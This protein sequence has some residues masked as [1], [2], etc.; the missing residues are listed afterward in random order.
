MRT[1][2]YRQNVSEPS[3]IA[4]YRVE[5]DPAIE[6]H[7]LVGARPHSAQGPENVA[8]GRLHSFES[9]APQ[10]S[11]QGNVRKRLGSLLYCTLARFHREALPDEFDSPA[12]DIVVVGAFEWNQVWVQELL[13]SLRQGGYRYRGRI[14]MAGPQVPYARK[15]TLKNLYR[16]ADYS[17]RGYAE[18]AI[19]ALACAHE[20]TLARSPSTPSALWPAED[21][22][23]LGPALLNFKGNNASKTFSPQ[24]KTR[25]A[26]EFDLQV[27]SLLVSPL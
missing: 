23:S 6:A 20:P 18:D 4:E 11:T 19:A 3:Q 5:N 17:A 26:S 16:G 25:G 9:A 8:W 2:T 10:C 27:G 12:A 13:S 14:G 24:R 15:R 1:R 21:R 7:A 22:S